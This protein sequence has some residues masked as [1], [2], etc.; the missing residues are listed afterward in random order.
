MSAGMGWLCCRRCPKAERCTAW[1]ERV[2]DELDRA[3][4]ELFHSLTDGG[5]DYD[6]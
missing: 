5:N 3:E 6:G 2:Q 4:P 1:C